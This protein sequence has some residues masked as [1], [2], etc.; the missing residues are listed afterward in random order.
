MKKPEKA[1]A[2]KAHG[3]ALLDA[4]RE[5]DDFEKFQVALES[6]SEV[7]LREAQDGNL[8]RAAVSLDLMSAALS[9]FDAGKS[10]ADL[11]PCYPIEA[12]RSETIEIPKAWVR[13]LADAWQAYKKSGPE[14]DLGEVLGVE[15]GG[16]G[17]QP[18]RVV[19]RS[20]QED[21]RRFN[22]VEIERTHAA[23]DGKFISLE[24]AIA[25]VA[26][27][28]GVSSDAVKRSYNK[29]REKRGNSFPK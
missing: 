14:T 4:F 6:W 26:G 1:A 29:I 2:I 19:L 7:L 5:L 18:A 12:W 20:L 13:P 17:K 15:G 11:R 10:H 23:I 25:T 9:A 3:E 8:S 16:Q 28:H 27:R 22:D 24:N 21:A